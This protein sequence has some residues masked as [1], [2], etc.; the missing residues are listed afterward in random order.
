MLNFNIER[1][2][3]KQLEDELQNLRGELAKMEEKVREKVY[4]K[5]FG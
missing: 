5:K 4:I 1:A 3:R 2:K